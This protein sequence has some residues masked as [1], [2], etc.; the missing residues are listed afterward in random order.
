MKTLITLV[1]PIA[2]VAGSSAFAQPN[3]AHDYSRTGIY[4]ESI[5]HKAVAGRSQQ[6]ESASNLPASLQYSR[7]GD[8]RKSEVAQR[9]AQQEERSFVE[10]L[11]ERTKV[12]APAGAPN[13]G[14]TT[15]P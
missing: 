15:N 9:N 4:E 10:V 1:I 5:T 12:V 14:G 3:T 7:T 6:D 11:N 8:Y 13:H 2:L